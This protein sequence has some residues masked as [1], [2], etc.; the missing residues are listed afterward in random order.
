[1]FRNVQFSHIFVRTSWL[2]QV[3]ES[4]VGYRIFNPQPISRYGIGKWSLIKQLRRGSAPFRMFFWASHQVGPQKPIKFALVEIDFLIM[5]Q[6]APHFPFLQRDCGWMFSEPSYNSVQSK[7]FRSGF[8]N[9]ATLPRQF[10]FSITI[11]RKLLGS[12]ARLSNIAT[13]LERSSFIAP[14]EDRLHLWSS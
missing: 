2:M 12:T 5:G 13:R 11:L 8:R 7:N 6:K 4:M 10:L 14:L 9:F 1:M 3:T